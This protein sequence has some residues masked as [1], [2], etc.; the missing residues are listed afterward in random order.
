[1]ENPCYTPA[2]IKVMHYYREA[3]FCADAFAGIG[4]LQ[5][6]N[7]LYYN[8][9]PLNLLGAY[10]SDLYGLF[11]FKLCPKPDVFDSVS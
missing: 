5:D 3:N 10:L 2:Q 7:I 8:S 9:P 6:L 11:H 1:M 4:S